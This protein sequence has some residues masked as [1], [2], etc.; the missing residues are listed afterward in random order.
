MRSRN[1]SD[2]A[3]TFREFVL[4]QNESSKRAHQELFS[5][6]DDR[7]IISGGDIVGSLLAVIDREPDRI[8]ISAGWEHLLRIALWTAARPLLSD[9]M[10]LLKKAGTSDADFAP[11]MKSD[12]DDL[13]PW[14]YYGRRLDILRRICNAAKSKAEMKINRKGLRVYCHLVSGDTQKIVASSL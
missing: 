8:H 1:N 11:F 5:F 2:S 14:L 9:V 3:V 10:I 12:I 7:Y 6:E 13:F 4:F